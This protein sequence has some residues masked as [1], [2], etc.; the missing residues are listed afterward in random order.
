MSIL[1]AKRNITIL[2]GDGKG[3]IKKYEFRRQNK[4]FARASQ[5][6]VHFFAVLHDYDVNLPINFTLYAGRKQATTK[7]YFSF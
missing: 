6:F 4:N 7:F 2:R 5:F 3:N 1:K